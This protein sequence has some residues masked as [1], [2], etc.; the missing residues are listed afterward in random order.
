M[1]TIIISTLILVTI[2]LMT[3][4]S[5]NT[6]GPSGT[7]TDG[8]ISGKVENW[9]L[10]NQKVSASIYK[11]GS[12]FP[13]TLG[14]GDIYNNGAFTINFNNPGEEYLSTIDNLF[15]DSSKSKLRINP[16]NAKYAI[17]V[18]SVVDA[19]GV[20]LGLIERRNFT[21]DITENSFYTEYV[22]FYR[23]VSVTGTKLSEYY[24]DTT[25]SE[26][27]V[28]SKSGWSTLTCLFTKLTSTYTSYIIRNQEPQDGKWYYYNLN[29]K[30]SVLNHRYKLPSI[31]K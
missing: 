9:A 27:N 19:N 12:T 4:C 18:L 21:D 29:D 15:N 31:F 14:T 30:A 5:D 11:P 2:V 28:N 7:S 26:Y 8:N 10:G 25:F 20:N 16:A 13:I 6:V 1:K 22:Y 24:S 23:D 3:S 17:L